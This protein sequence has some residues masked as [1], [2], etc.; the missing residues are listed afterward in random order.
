MTTKVALVIGSSRGIG[1]QLAV[2]LASQGYIVVL[3]A[4]STSDATKCDPFPPDPNSPSSTINTVAREITENGGRAT[5]IAA[6]VRDGASITSL[7]TQT[8]TLH[9]R[10]DVLVYNSGAIWWDSVA[11]TPAKRFKLMQQ[12]NPEGLYICVQKCLPHLYNTS[13]RLVVVSP[14][15]Y[16]RFLRGKTAYA[17]GKWGMSALTMGLAMDF[18]REGREGMAITSLWPAVAIE[19]A[20][21]KVHLSEEDKKDLRK[22]TIFSHAVLEIL[23]APAAEV[24]GR[25]LLDED[26]LREKGVRDFGKYSLVPGTVPRRIMPES[27]PDLSVKEQDDEGRRMTSKI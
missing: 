1:R 3:S 2:D 19:S 12:V 8:I 10:L 26:Y 13:G 21:T 4:K 24:N 15:I 25:C 20:A 6:D 18:V 7:V 5:A 14:P 22:A 23:R 27:L 11:Q 16:S 9:G 17:M